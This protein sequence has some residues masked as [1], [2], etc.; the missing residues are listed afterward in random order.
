ME[1][2]EPGFKLERLPCDK[3]VVRKNTQHWLVQVSCGLGLGGRSALA[4]ICALWREEVPYLLWQQRSHKSW[5]SCAR[6]RPEGILCSTSSL[7]SAPFCSC[8]QSLVF[9]R[10]TKANNSVNLASPALSTDLCFNIDYELNVK[11][12][13]DY[14]ILIVSSSVPVTSK[15]G[16][17]LF[18]A[19]LLTKSP[20]LPEHLFQGKCVGTL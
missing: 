13:C 12:F 19:G 5:S 15:D 3:G 2:I 4:K 9:L 6:Q 14:C 7:L 10:K 20:F 17:T 1:L 16:T 18:F 11:L 8:G